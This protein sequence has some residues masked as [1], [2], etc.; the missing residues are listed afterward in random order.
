[1]PFLKIHQEQPV[2]Y[3]HNYINEQHLHTGGFLIVSAVSMFT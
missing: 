2:F 1:M 3:I